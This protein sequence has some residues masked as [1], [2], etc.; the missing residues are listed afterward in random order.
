MLDKDQVL[1]DRYRIQRRLGS[2]GMGAVYLATIEALD[3]K[4]V[5]IK[6]LTANSNPMEREQAAEQFRK[7]ASFLAN[8]KHPNLVAVSDFFIEDGHSYLVM[9]H[10]EGENLVQKM[11]QQ[12]DF[13]F[14]A[15][16]VQE[17]ALSLCDVLSYLHQQDPPILFRDLKPGNIMI[18]EQGKVILIDFGIARTQAVGEQTGTFLQGVGTAGFA[19]LEQHSGPGSTDQRTDVYALGATLYNLLTGDV[20]ADAASRAAGLAQL[21]SPKDILD[22]VPDSLSDT[23]LRCL[24]LK[25]GSRFQSIDAVRRALAQESV[26]KELF[27][28][29]LLDPTQEIEKEPEAE[30]EPSQTSTPTPLLKNAGL[31]LVTALL[32]GLFFLPLATS[33]PEADDIHRQKSTPDFTAHLET[34][35]TGAVAVARAGL[36]WLKLKGAPIE[37]PKTD[38]LVEAFDTPSPTPEDFMAVLGDELEQQSIPSYAFE[39]DGWRGR[40]DPELEQI[41]YPTE[42]LLLDA[43]DGDAACWIQIG[44]YEEQDNKYRRLGERWVTVVGFLD[45]DLLV[46]DPHPKSGQGKQ[47]HNLKM[48]EL[49]ASSELIGEDPDLPISG[50]KQ[51]ELTGPLHPLAGADTAIIDSLVV[52]WYPEAPE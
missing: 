22:T 47:A 34:D 41:P 52:L 27:D 16:Q 13:R 49:P 17:W 32:I 4:K 5:A 21:A 24:E 26:S 50:N 9:D 31:L 46:F 19:A 11:R 3:H 42:D 7:E 37:V 33:N 25:P 28:N 14:A 38:T 43:L 30:P 23:V 1:S 18:N 40:H 12:P 35:P 29:S 20:P 48:V 10:V 6:E 15:E 45:D 36:S 2:G 8:L 44:W 39:S 51:M